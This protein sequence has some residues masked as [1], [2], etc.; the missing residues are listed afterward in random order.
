MKKYISLIL[1]CAA[2]T[3]FSQTI[4]SKALK[5]KYTLEDSWTAKEFGGP[6]NW[7]QSG[8]DMC[9]CSGVAFSKPDAKGKYNVV[10]YAV[11]AGGLD[12]AKR[13]FVGALHFVN[14]QKIEKA[15]NENFSFERRRSNFVDVKTKATS[16][17]CLRYITKAKDG[18]SYMIYAWQ[19]NME[20][21]NSTAERELSKMIN[22]IEPL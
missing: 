1:I 22:V 8:N 2:V 20:L 21:L 10:V 9:R 3:S 19:E 6:L 13:E 18:Y 15:V 7:D 11:P 17:N 16:Y 12:S 4:K 5:L 14:V